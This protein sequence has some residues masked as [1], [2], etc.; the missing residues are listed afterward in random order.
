MDVHKN[1]SFNIILSQGIYHEIKD[2]IIIL[3]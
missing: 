2:K 3:W 1:D